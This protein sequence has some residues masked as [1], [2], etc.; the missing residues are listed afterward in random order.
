MAVLCWSLFLAVPLLAREK[1]DVIIMKNGDR[2]TCE[3]KGLASDTLYVR[4]DYILGVSSIE[5]SKVDHVESKQL[6]IVKTQDGLV[7]SGMLSTPESSGGRPV[8]IEILEPSDTRVEIEK[9][10][11]I[12]MDETASTIWQRFNGDIG[13]GV[14]YSKGNQSTQYNFSS[15]LNYPRERW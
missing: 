15:S 11:I 8:K 1:N 13:L 10:Q 14:I 6:F 7:Y 12:K 3:I 4:V 5:W 2:I 9:S